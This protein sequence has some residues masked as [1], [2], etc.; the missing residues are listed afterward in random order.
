MG[1]WGLLG[2]AL[3]GFGAGFAGGVLFERLQKVH[4]DGQGRCAGC[5]R[6]SRLRRLDIDPDADATIPLPNRCKIWDPTTEDGRHEIANFIIN[7]DS[8]QR[9]L[10]YLA[11]MA[12]PFPEYREVSHVLADLQ[13]PL[14]NRRADV[15]TSAIWTR[16]VPAVWAALPHPTHR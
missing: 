2:A 13:K 3:V 8:Q 9:S 15:S 5:I 1:L 12:K 11:A 4:L 16:I 7:V 14:D 10:N 6:W